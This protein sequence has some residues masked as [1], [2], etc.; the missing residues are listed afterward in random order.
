MAGAEPTRSERVERRLA[1]LRKLSNADLFARYDTAADPDWDDEKDQITRENVLVEVVRRGGR[2]AEKW[3][4]AKMSVDYEAKIKAKE[5]GDRDT[6]R[7]LERNLEIFTALRRVQKKS[8]PVTLTVTLPK[9]DVAGTRHLPTVHVKLTNTDPEK[10]PVWFQFGGDNRSGRLAR[11]RFEVADDTGRRIEP[12]VWRS[13]IG[14]GIFEEAPLA[15]GQSWES[16]L[17]MGDYV[18]LTEP[19]EY[20]VRVLYHNQATIADMDNVSGLIMCESK[21][22]K[23]KVVKGPKTTIYVGPADRAQAAEAIAALDETGSVRAVI[24]RY[25]PEYYDFI[26]PE[27]PEGRLHKLGWRAVPSLLVSLRDN[28]LSPGRR[29]WVVGLLY[30]FTREPGMNPFGLRA[31]WDHVLGGYDYKSSFG[32]EGSSTGGKIEVANQKILAERW[33]KFGDDYLDLREPKK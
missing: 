16:D 4:W 11:W 25:G 10:L 26:P 3:L 5:R 12:F 33:L 7:R 23:I 20:T 19:G 8:D 22:F 28:K 15:D 2:A 17:R 30:A 13:V 14:G 1:E 31:D 24:G 9:D 29:S 32:R 18:R 27:S 21:P 6:A